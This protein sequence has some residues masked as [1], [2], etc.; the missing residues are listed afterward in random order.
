MTDQPTFV[1]IQTTGWVPELQT[2][3]PTAGIAVSIMVPVGGPEGKWLTKECATPSEL[4]SY[5]QA[6]DR[7]RKAAL[8]W[9][10]DYHGPMET[11]RKRTLS[12]EEMLHELD[13]F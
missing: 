10:F 1:L 8:A 7:D 2:D 13:S 5:L 6:L 12:A 3:G 4:W 11:A 9:N